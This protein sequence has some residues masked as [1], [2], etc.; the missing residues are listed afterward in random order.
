MSFFTSSTAPIKQAV[1]KIPKCGSCG[2]YKNC[3]SPKMKYSG[4]GRKGILLIG[5]A[6]GK[7]EDQEGIQFVGKAG[8]HLENHLLDWDIDMRKDCWITNSL[9][10]WPGEGNKIPHPKMVDY[11]RPLVFNTINELQP[12]VIICLGLTA[13]KSLIGHLW[14]EDVGPMARWAGWK[15]P[16]QN[17]NSWIIPTYHPSYLLRENNPVLELHFSRHIGQ[18]L[19]LKDKP[20]KVLPTYEQQ[21][22]CIEN[23]TLAAKKLRRLIARRPEMVAYDYETDILKPDSKEA[24]IVC[25]SVSDGKT[26]L[27]YPWHG[28]AI[29]ATK[30]LLLNPEIKKVM[31]NS[32]FEIR[33]TRAKL[34]IDVVNCVWDTMV[35]AHVLDNRKGSK[36]GGITGLK[37]QSFVRLGQPSY[38][39]HIKPFLKAKGS[40][41][42]N[43]VR[44]VSLPD[45]LKYCGLDS[46]L[47][48]VIAKQQMEEM[49]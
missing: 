3:K 24:E 1:S 12:N 45:L 48:I 47:E 18:T 11:C 39:D 25:C 34:G 4:K 42:K 13:V 46:L 27:A 36:E 29:E 31:S 15:I 38:D 17:P 33:W 23:P 35:A 32:K 21:I 14:K 43:R 44:E 19:T 10:C 16:S 2:L 49:K 28:E 7:T 9:S 8:Q 20:W 22:K 26:T 5:E 40:N 37:F 30:E 41:K 6:P